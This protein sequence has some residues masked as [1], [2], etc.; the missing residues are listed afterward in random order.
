MAD[1]AKESL[2]YPDG[3]GPL[4]GLCKDLAKDE[5]ILTN[6]LSTGRILRWSAPKMVGV[7]NFTTLAQNY[8]VVEKLLNI[9][10]PQNEVPKTILIEDAREQDAII[11]T[12]FKL[13]SAYW[14]VMVRPKPSS[15]E[16][17]EDPEEVDGHHPDEVD[18]AELA[19]E[20]GVLAG[21]A[22]P[23][24]PVP[25]SQ[26]PDSQVLE[27]QLLE[28]LVEYPDPDMFDD[29]QVPDSQ[30]PETQLLE[31]LVE[32][33]DPDMFG[34]PETQLL[35]SPVDYPDPDMVNDSLVPAN[36]CPIV[37]Q[38]SSENV[39]EDGV[40][41]GSKDSAASPASAQSESITPTE[42]ENTPSPP[43]GLMVA[44]RSLILHAFLSE[45]CRRRTPQRSKIN[46]RQQPRPLQRAPLAPSVPAVDPSTLDTLPMFSD[47]LEDSSEGVEAGDKSHGLS[48]LP[49]GEVNSDLPADLPHGKVHNE[50]PA[51]LPGG[52]V[53]DQLEAGAHGDQMEPKGLDQPV[54]HLPD[55][56]C[57]GTLDQPLA[58]DAKRLHDEPEPAA[59][60]TVVTDKVDGDHGGAV[61]PEGPKGG[62]EQSDPADEPG[63][64]FNAEVETTRQEQFAERDRLAQEAPPTKKQA[65]AAAAKQKKADAKAKAKLEKERKKALA[66]AKAKFQKDKAKEAK[67]K[68]KE[69]K[70]AKAAKAAAKKTATKGRQNKNKE[71]QDEGTAETHEIEV[72]SVP[73]EAEEPEVNAEAEEPQVK[74]ARKSRTKKTNKTDKPEQ[75]TATGDRLPAAPEASCPA[76][77]EVS[78]D[79]QHKRKA[80]DL[81][82]GA[83]TKESPK[84]KAIFARR[85]RGKGEKTGKRWDNIKAV[86]MDFVAPIFLAEN[87]SLGMEMENS[88]ISPSWSSETLIRG[89]GIVHS[90]TM[91]LE[92]DPE[93]AKLLEELARLEA[94]EKALMESKY[95]AAPES[96]VV[97]DM[98]DD[99]LQILFVKEAKNAIR[100]A[101]VKNEVVEEEVSS[102]TKVCDHAPAEPTYPEPQ[103]HPVETEVTVPAEI[104]ED[105]ESPTGLDPMDEETTPSEPEA[106]VLIAF[107][108][109]EE[110]DGNQ[111]D[112]ESTVG[113]PCS[114]SMLPGDTEN[115]DE[116]MKGQATSSGEVPTDP[117]DSQV[118]PSNPPAP[119]P[120]VPQ[121]GMAPTGIPQPPALVKQ[122]PGQSTEQGGASHGA[123]PSVEKTTQLQSMPPPPVPTQ[124]KRS[125]G[126]QDPYFETLSIPP[127]VLSDNAI[128]N[129]LYRVFKAKKDGTYDVDEKWVKAWQ[130]VKDG[131][132]QLYSMFEKTGYSVEK[133]VKRCKAITESISEESSEVEGEWLTYADMQKLEFSETKIKGVIR[134]CESRP[135]L[136]RMSKY[137]EGQMYWT[138]IRCKGSLKRSKRHIYQEIAE[139]DEANDPSQ[140]SEKPSMDWTM[141]TDKQSGV[142]A[143]ADDVKPEETEMIAP[144]PVDAKDENE[145]GANCECPEYA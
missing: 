56:P 11:A 87:C 48:D 50:L 92:S 25:D 129:R 116:M 26:I 133:F 144:I 93:H 115:A 51:D 24:E 126:D 13:V 118:P 15:Q 18:D 1:P 102:P 114:K 40:N 4:K 77:A 88:T 57:P 99:D 10:L 44:S 107:P 123:S 80:E 3:E 98:A 9:W 22:E 29:S 112:D 104:P 69:A 39:F 100:E 119:T 7:I 64:L 6:A 96:V 91:S 58:C 45:C 5:Q 145:A 16:S 21:V 143:L 66:K 41:L 108:W 94:L 12:L 32:Y 128:Y 2:E 142:L 105:T 131:R 59:L 37:R 106:P 120:P 138:E 89:V 27:T 62:D 28:S 125:R 72:P 53:N 46:V 90:A 54:A 137:G 23:V 95:A 124:K 70:K 111:E 8:R 17:L 75:A 63:D 73:A 122:D 65:K 132:S 34:V 52:E 76:P 140:P 49:H 86:F 141:L 83:D 139:W 97:E 78:D 47:F 20:L 33:P 109:N 14:P 19:Q 79:P 38:D 121:G 42:I 117:A 101:L 113:Y 36:D 31:S 61:A 67:A 136:Q 110:D 55:Q 35:E 60:Q 74:K 43:Q 81:P 84:E 30:V 85:V 135:H 127:P 130:D 134:Y 71:T 103:D 82:D 68:A